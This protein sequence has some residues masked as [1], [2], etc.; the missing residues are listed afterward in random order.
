LTG[1]N[2]VVLAGFVVIV[3]FAL[4]TVSGLR[5]VLKVN[6]IVLFTATPVAVSTGSEEEISNS[7]ALDANLYA[8]SIAIVVADIL[9]YYHH[10][11]A[12]GHLINKYTPSIKWNSLKKYEGVYE[13]RC[14]EA[15]ATQVS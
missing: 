12:A 1:S 5:G 4:V 7:G 6:V 14:E 10:I 2:V 15:K 3:I 9:L 8:R 13:H 11:I